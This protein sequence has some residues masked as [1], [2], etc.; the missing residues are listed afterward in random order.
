MKLANHQSSDRTEYDTS[1]LYLSGSEVYIDH[2]F[3]C[4]H[5]S[6]VGVMIQRN[7]ALFVRHGRRITEQNPLLT[8]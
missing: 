7:S 5:S 3:P 1:F 2:E 6:Y 4:L 8:I